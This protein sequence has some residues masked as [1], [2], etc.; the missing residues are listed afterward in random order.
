MGG[1]GGREGR[2]ELID[3]GVSS[4]SPTHPYMDLF[5]LT[6]P[7]LPSPPPP[8]L[9]LSNSLSPDTKKNGSTPK[10]TENGWNLWWKCVKRKESTW[11]RFWEFREAG[12]A[13]GGFAE[14]GERGGEVR[15]RRLELAEGGR[16]FFC[17]AG[18]RPR[19]FSVFK[20][21]PPPSTSSSPR[22]AL[23]PPLR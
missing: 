17:R 5:S 9:P 19:F 15:G 4:I 2:R 22:G 14:R 10:S 13:G 11:T 7:S 21:Q 8:L 1:E 16:L 20:L 23:P 18:L 3:T 12:R 6:S